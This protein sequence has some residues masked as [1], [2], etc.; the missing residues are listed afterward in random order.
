MSWV[1]IF[2]RAILM[3]YFQVVIFINHEPGLSQMINMKVKLI[4]LPVACA[5][6]TVGK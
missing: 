2:C 3:P 6:A 1:T 4:T 5:S